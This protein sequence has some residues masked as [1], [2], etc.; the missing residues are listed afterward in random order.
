M[1]AK[2]EDHKSK[3]FKFEQGGKTFT[4]PSF[5]SLPMGA[6]RKARKGKDEIDSVFI[7]VEETMGEGSPELAAIDAMDAAEFNA[8]LEAWTEGAGVGEASSSES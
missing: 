8:F 2:P 5:S 3:T 1:T 7:I 6:T 4:I